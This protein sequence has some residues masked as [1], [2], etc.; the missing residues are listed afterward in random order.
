[1]QIRARSLAARDPQFGLILMDLRFLNAP[2]SRFVQKFPSS[3]PLTPA[4]LADYMGD[5]V[6]AIQYLLQRFLNRVSR[7]RPF[8]AKALEPVIA[9]FRAHTNETLRQMSLDLP[10]PAVGPE[11]SLESRRTADILERSARLEAHISGLSGELFMAVA[12]PG[13]LRTSTKVRDIPELEV[14][15]KRLQTSITARILKNP[16]ELRTYQKSFPRLF[17]DPL[18]RTPVSEPLQRS[19][20]RIWDRILNEEIDVFR[21][22]RG[23]YF[24]GESKVSS[25][26]IDAGEFAK[27]AGSH[28]SRAEQAESKRQLAR[29]LSL[30]GVKVNHEYMASAGFEKTLAAELIARGW[31]LHSPPPCTLLAEGQGE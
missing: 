6:A 10:E 25:R 14:V 12:L 4:L 24:I 13:T 15:V 16:E 31:I 3:R 27:K 7:D 28:H 21:I 19:L 5:K 29:W 22:W 26:P 23:E 20:A 1:M 8:F 18:E 17:L 30:D 9:S 2:L 11:S